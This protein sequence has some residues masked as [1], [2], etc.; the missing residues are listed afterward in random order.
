M[1]DEKAL[2]LGK[3]HTL[4]FPDTFPVVHYFCEKKYKT[5]EDMQFHKHFEFGICLEGQGIFFIGNR[6]IPFTQGNVSIIPPGTPHFAQSL[7]SH[8]S[9]WMFVALDASGLSCSPGSIAPNIVYDKATEQLLRI[10][11]EELDSK[12]DGYEDAV[13][14]LF[15]ILFIRAS[16]L[17]TDAPIFFTYEDGLAAIYPAIEYITQHYPED[18]GIDALASLCNMSLS[19]FRRKFTAVTGMTPLRYLLMMRLRM[20]GVLLKQTERKVSDIALEVGYNTL[21]SFNRHF[22]ENYGM[23]PKDYRASLK[24]PDEN[25][26]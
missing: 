4:D 21:S 7:D 13:T 20:A 6:M 3:L 23:S 8:P 18:I 22:K 2:P 9:K 12:S 11:A 26:F 16:R 19:H 15:D 14:K 10:V 5:A 24:N 1:K 25:I 17:D